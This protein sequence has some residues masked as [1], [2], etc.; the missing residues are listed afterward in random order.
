VTGFDHADSRP[1][2]AHV[3]PNQAHIN[4]PDGTSISIQFDKLVITAGGDSGQV[5]LHTQIYPIPYCGIYKMFNTHIINH[6]ISIF[7][8]E[9]LDLPTAKSLL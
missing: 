6:K 5:R 3:R 1:N 9:A 7:I 4:L 8:K 2:Q